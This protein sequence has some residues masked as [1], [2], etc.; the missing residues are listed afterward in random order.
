MGAPGTKLLT[1]SS[2]ICQILLCL[3]F[4]WPAKGMV[5]PSILYFNRYTIDDGLPTD[6]VRGILKDPKGY[7]WIGT[8]D[9]LCRFDGFSFQVFGREEIRQTSEYIRSI[10]SDSA[11]HIWVETP[12]GLSI[13]DP[14]KGTFKEAGALLGRDLSSPLTA[15]HA[16]SEGHVWLGLQNQGILEVNTDGWQSRER[17]VQDGKQ[18]YP[19]NLSALLISRRDN[20]CMIGLA[21]QGLWITDTTYTGLVPFQTEEGE[22]PFKDAFVKVILP[23]GQDEYF[24]C[25]GARRVSRI[26]VAEKTCKLW[27]AELGGG[28]KISDISFVG[29]ETLAVLTNAGVFFYGTRDG[30]LVR[31]AHNPSEPNSLPGN[32]AL[33]LAGNLKDGLAIAM[34][35]DGLA[36][37]QRNHLSIRRITYAT[38]ASGRDISLAGSHV[39]GFA[40]DGNGTI[41][42]ATRQKGLFSYDPAEDRLVPYVGKEPFPALLITLFAQ[43]DDLWVSTMQG[44]YHIRTGSGEVER[45]RHYSPSVITTGA[46]GRLLL[47]TE[48]GLISYDP[49]TQRFRHASLPRIRDISDILKDS[50]GW[51]WYASRSEGLWRQTENGVEP[52]EIKTPDGR[53]CHWILSLAEDTHGDIWAAVLGEG[54]ACIH[55]D[56]SYVFHDQVAG[57]QGNLVS[58]AIADTLGNLWITTDNGLV[59]MRSEQTAVRYSTQDGLLENRLSP[60]AS[61]C[62][63]NGRLFFGSRNGLMIVQPK[64]TP[65]DEVPARLE[66]CE[67]Y[68]GAKRMEPGMPGSPLKASMARTGRLVLRNDQNSFSFRIAMT[69]PSTYPSGEVLYKLENYDS[70]WTILRSSHPVNYAKVPP[71]HYVFKAK[72]KSIPGDWEAECDPVKVIIRPPFY[73]SG[74]AWALYAALLAGLVF[75]F[76]RQ[77]RKR[78]QTRMQERELKMKMDLTDEKVRFFTT[79]AHEIKTP[80]TLIRTPLEHVLTHGKVDGDAAEDLKIIE[81]NAG[82]LGRLIDELLDF[83]RF[84]NK[85]YELSRTRLDLGEE[86]HFIGLSYDAEFASKKIDYLLDRPDTPLWVQ[87]DRSALAKILNNLFLNAIKYADSFLEVHLTQD[88]GQ[89][90]AIFVNDGPV[91]PAGQRSKI[92]EPFVQASSETRSR[93]GFGIGLSVASTLARLHGGSLGMDD[94]MNCNRFILSLPACPAEE[95]LQAASAE[96]EAAETADPAADDSSVILLVEDDAGLRE[97]L[98]GKLSAE[99]RVLTASDGEEALSVMAA[100]ERVDVV[101]T[102]IVMPKMDGLALCRNIRDNFETSHMIVII[103]SANLDE[104]RR[105][106][107]MENGADMVVEK[108][109]SLDFLISCIDNLVHGRKA[110]LDR[111]MGETDQGSNA[112][113]PHAPLPDR[114]TQ[115]LEKMNQLLL[116][117]LSNPDYSI[118]QLASELGVSTSHLSRKIKS[119]TRLSF[120]SYVRELR[121]A[122]SEALLRSGEL[123]VAEIA[124]GVGFQTPSYFIKRFK[125]KYGKTPKEYLADLTAAQT[126]DNI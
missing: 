84:G 105:I 108:P 22:I 2:L 37:Q 29:P 116:D 41:W 45:F 66:I 3:L 25:T 117:N 81:K 73:L 107:S 92:F 19:S 32:T 64:N 101:V 79:V 111:L 4:S 102:D 71:G 30:R 53:D 70:D 6:E 89:V 93:N 31:M 56:G 78:E 100:A 104:S 51:M 27:D 15:F 33:Q 34:G 42:V 62:D 98:R 125:E 28:V 96:P 80:L 65:L 77:S 103:L 67:L 123:R 95:G 86:V 88:N 114:D 35:A 26:N 5:D 57:L 124:Y 118:G 38:P 119:M 97:W 74:F 110:L 1:G 115:F 60:H 14:D 8:S 121:L 40:E 23:A 99:Y 120:V 112:P 11:G 52:V 94:D 106:T 126:T 10:H 36:I 21:H 9:G 44:L 43:D 83:S 17:F 13:Y 90:R 46:D 87:A 39:C 63:R 7:L 55:R 47:G 85:N 72:A 49:E 75:W 109:F 48:T 113:G 61:L 50:R 54:I 59:E 12:D 20:L 76:L 82:Y 18:V 91:V 69:G 16:D 122:R 68:L 58:N 24:V